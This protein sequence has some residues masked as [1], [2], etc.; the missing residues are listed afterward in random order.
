MSKRPVRDNRRRMRKNRDKLR[1]IS[2]VQRAFR[3]EEPVHDR[4]LLRTTNNV[5]EVTD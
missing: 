2:Q 4:P 3:K 1:Q 5:G